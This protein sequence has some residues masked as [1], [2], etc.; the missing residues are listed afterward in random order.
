[1]ELRVIE[2]DE[3]LTHLVLIG[4]L[5]LA[6][7]QQV[8]TKFLAYTVARKRPA[9]VDISGVDYLVS[10]AIRMLISA[11]KAMHANSTRLALLNPQRQVEDTLRLANLQQLMIITHDEAEA[12]SQLLSGLTRA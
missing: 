5:D 1:M 10:F 12:R 6:G 9:L 7:V 8:E 4:R 3:P 11:A 2:T